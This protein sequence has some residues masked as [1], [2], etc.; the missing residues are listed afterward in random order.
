MSE[1]RP[2]RVAFFFTTLELGGTERQ[3]LNLIEHLNRDRV[4]P[5]AYA[6][7][8]GA[9]HAT[10]AQLHVPVR[11][12]AD[13]G[14]GILGA[15][16]SVRHWL[17]EDNVDILHALLWH[18]NI[19]SRFACAGTRVR[20]INSIRWAER[21][22]RDIIDYATRWRVDHWIANSE[23]GAR[24]ARLPRSKTNIIHNGIDEKLLKTPLSAWKPVP[25][26]VTMVAQFRRE[27]RYDVFIRAAALLPDWTFQCVGDGENLAVMQKFAQSLGVRNIH[28]LG[29]R[30]DVPEI[31]LHSAV[32]VLLSRSE[33]S[34]NTALE[35]MALGVP[36]IGSDIPAHRE[37]LAHGRGTL[38]HTTDAKYLA[39]TLQ[40]IAG[41]RAKEQETRRQKT[42][43]Y[44]VETY[45]ISRM[46]EQT[47]QIYE[48]LDT[49]GRD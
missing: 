22:P 30:D 43:R 42:K 46:V 47:T 34:P 41:V 24:L 6:I 5:I 9:L 35:S 3:A 25:K 33:G 49:R 23:H 20:C 38:V 36:F 11:V 28:F 17:R 48:R 31:L 8:G 19:I 21:R 45:A 32:A 27:K 44:V 15:S 40:T 18:T 1:K 2:I 7:K 16:R 37:L 10:L 26:T 12:L 29:K 13:E 14:A 39:N 4:T